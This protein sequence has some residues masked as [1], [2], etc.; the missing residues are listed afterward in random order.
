MTDLATG[1]RA[2]VFPSQLLQLMAGRELP[3]CT[4]GAEVYPRD[5][6]CTHGNARLCDGFL[7]DRHRGG[8]IRL[9]A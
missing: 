3:I 1:K 8:C 4:A 2:R 7:E 9:R 6:L 5:N